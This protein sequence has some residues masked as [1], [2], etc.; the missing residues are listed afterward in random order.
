MEKMEA[1]FQKRVEEYDSHM[2]TEVVG[3]REGYR[4]MAQLLPAQTRTLLDLGCGT[5]LELD[6]IF[7]RFPALRVT[8]V[9][10]TQAMLDKLRQ[11]HPEKQL[12]LICGDY[13]KL[14]FGAEAFDAA[15]SFQ[16]MHHFTHAKKRALYEKVR[17]AIKP[18]GV[19]LECDYMVETQ[20]EED[21]WFAEGQRLLSEMG[22]GAI[23]EYHYDTPC[24]IDNQIR[25]LQEAGFADVKLMLRLENTTL[26]A[27]KAPLC[28][29]TK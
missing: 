18:G 22:E 11:K 25:L 10:L 4:K 29:K 16:T 26:L 5:G 20:Q 27:A 6:E 19:Y 24:S 9:D 1:F 2:L 17:A 3:C 28:P 23:G 21:H 12:T 7:K 14:D 8:G 13:F 15:V